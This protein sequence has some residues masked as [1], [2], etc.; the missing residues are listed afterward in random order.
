MNTRY[1]VVT[2]TGDEYGF[3]TLEQ[4]CVKAIELAER[5]GCHVDVVDEDTEETVFVALP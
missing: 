1:T 2:A 5:S 4:A 3:V